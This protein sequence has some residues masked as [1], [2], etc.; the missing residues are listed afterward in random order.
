MH[1]VT[2]YLSNAPSTI[3]VIFG[4]QLNSAL[5]QVKFHFIFYKKTF[6]MNVNV[7]L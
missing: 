5:D 4:K 1:I 6:N 7:L 3:L 2:E